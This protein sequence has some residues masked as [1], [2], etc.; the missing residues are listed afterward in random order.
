MKKSKL[1][2]I[3]GIVL[4]S[5]IALAAGILLLPE[6][7]CTHSDPSLIVTLEGKEATCQET[8]LTSGT[9]CDKCG[10][11]VIPQTVIEKKDC[12][13]Y[14]LNSD[15]TYK[16]YR[17]SD[18]GCECT[19]IVIPET[20]NGVRVTSIGDFAF[21]SCDTITSIT[22]PDSVIS[23]GKNAFSYC[24]AL[25]SIEMPSS[26][27]IIG[28]A[29]FYNCTSLASVK[30]PE[31]II[32]IPDYLFDGCKS[33]SSIEIPTSVQSMGRGVFNG[34]DFLKSIELPA[35]LKNM[36]VFVFDG[37]T[38]IE[39]ITFGCD[40]PDFICQNLS[41]LTTVVL[42]NG[43]TKI[44]VAAFSECDS[45][46]SIVIPSTVSS[47]GDYAFTLCSSLES[48]IIPSSVYSLG[49]A[50]FSSCD[51]LKINCEAFSQPDS[52]NE[53]WNFSDRP[54]VWGYTN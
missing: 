8:G 42:K 32:S 6:A 15:G 22:I 51:V 46:T 20:Y 49:Y 13:T 16:V 18:Y 28:E 2:I 52:W 34:C 19:E 45:L 26:V 10:E 29:A 3:I 5:V 1:F 24:S 53:A 30:I 43:V 44:G 9:K 14:T 17:R 48:V 11:I 41:S 47:I 36:D 23:I 7:K 50:A 25:S 54:V 37:C 31:S 21:S 33:L 27:K 38:A 39:S 4:V 12:L 35:S 40:V